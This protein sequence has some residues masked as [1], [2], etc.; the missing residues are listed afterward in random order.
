MS[1]LRIVATAVLGVLGLAAGGGLIATF[2]VDKSPDPAVV[3]ALATNFGTAVGGVAGIATSSQ[4]DTD[5]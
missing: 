2:M 3:V 4:K 1:S 5:G